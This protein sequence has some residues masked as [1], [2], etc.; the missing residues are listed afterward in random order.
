MSADEDKG[1]ALTW[2]HPPSILE[3]IIIMGRY[4]VDNLFAGWGRR[5]G[6]GV[7]NQT[8]QL[9]EHSLANIGVRAGMVGMDISAVGE[10]KVW[11]CYF[12]SVILQPIFA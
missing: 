8:D 6:S 7:G 1:V 5:D 10:L 2:Q 4:V 9:V 12:F 11:I 3:V